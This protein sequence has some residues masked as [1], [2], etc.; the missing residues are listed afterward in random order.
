MVLTFYFV[1]EF[2][3]WRPLN[4]TSS[5]VLFQWLSLFVIILQKTNLRLFLTNIWALSHDSENTERKIEELLKD[6]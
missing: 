1:D 3:W 6:E 5:E 2:H 4:E